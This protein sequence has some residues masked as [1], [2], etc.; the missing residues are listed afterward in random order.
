MYKVKKVLNEIFGAVGSQVGQQTQTIQPQV[1]QPPVV[2]P[3]V[4]NQE[5]LSITKQIDQ[6][7]NQINELTTTK[8]KLTA[9]LAT[10]SQPTQ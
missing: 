8:N 4:D 7:T 6:I 10:I 9:R 5:Q 3:Q 1:K 2:K